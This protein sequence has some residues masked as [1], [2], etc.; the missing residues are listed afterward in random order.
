MATVQ[1]TLSPEVTALGDK[2]FKD[3]EAVGRAVGK[4]L[5]WTGRKGGWIYRA[6]GECAPRVITQGWASAG[7]VA[8]SGSNMG[9]NLARRYSP[10]HKGYRLFPE[11][12]VTI[13][14]KLNR[15]RA[16]GWV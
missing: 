16:K 15:Y 9:N 4:L 8:I 7:H 2:T 5:G 12:L 3:Q 11:D 1:V 6:N 10:D 14:A 13:Q